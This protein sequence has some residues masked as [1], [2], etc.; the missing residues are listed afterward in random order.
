MRDVETWRLRDNLNKD[1]E[2]LLVAIDTS[3]YESAAMA[4]RIR[5]TVELF[6]N[7][8]P[9]I[10]SFVLNMSFAIIPCGDFPKVDFVDYTN[11]LEQYGLADRCHILAQPIRGTG[12]TCQELG[13]LADQANTAGIFHTVTQNLREEFFYRVPA[14]TEGRQ[15][16]LRFPITYQGG[17]A[18]PA[19]TLFAVLS[20][21]EFVSVRN[22]VYETYI[23]PQLPQVFRAYR[24]PEWNG[25]RLPSFILTG[26][27][28][29][30]EDENN[31]DEQE[32]SG[33]EENVVTTITVDV[34][35]IVTPVASL[36]VTPGVQVTPTLLS[37]TATPS[38]TPAPK[39]PFYDLFDG[40]GNNDMCD[41]ALNCV[42]V[43]AAGNDGLPYPYAPA[44]FQTAISVS[45]EYSG[46]N[47]CLGSFQGGGV[48]VSNKGEIQMHGFYNCLPGTSFAA[49]RLSYLMAL[50]FASGS[51][52]S[53]CTSGPTTTP[54]PAA[55]TASD[56]PL[57]S[58]EWTTGQWADATI[59]EASDKYCQDFDNIVFAP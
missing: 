37:F 33:G 32:N 4:L 36:T 11:M 15:S 22:A 44:L 9:P 48:L 35:V 2:I 53:D 49:P 30:S 56:T 28:S 19:E 25:E 47:F 43:A 6:Q 31:G 59:F 51:T 34:P 10:T 29:D 27:S 52:V 55:L 20:Q 40:D 1:Y 46:A 38:P 57:N 42:P 12:Q 41:P 18:T 45:A 54:T 50:Y 24:A 16:P 13:T 23:V 5:E 3:E 26:E 58:A 14:N 8:Q 21:P 39:D 17:D 7:R